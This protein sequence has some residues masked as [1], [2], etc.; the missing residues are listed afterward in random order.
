VSADAGGTPTPPHGAG[1]AEE[2]CPIC[3]APLRE[4]QDWCLRCGTAARTRLAPVPRWRP[5]VVGIAVVALLSIAGLAV[6][7]VELAGGSSQSGTPTGTVATTAAPPVSSPAAITFTTSSALITTTAPVTLIT[8]T[9][10][11]AITSLR[12]AGN[13]PAAGANGQRSS[14]SS[15]THTASTTSTQATP[16]H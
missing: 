9:A 16:K 8:T 5:L 2:H 6:A 11:T 12:A 4:D 13:A 14:S 15:K 7:L 1:D 10:A 3:G